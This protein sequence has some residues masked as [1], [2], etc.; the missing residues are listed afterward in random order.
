LVPRRRTSVK[1]QPPASSSLP[2]Q[3]TL[4]EILSQP[5]TWEETKQELER[6]GVFAQVAETF[7]PTDPWL[8]VACGSSYYLSQIIAHLWSRLLK[9]PCRALPASELLFD[10]EKLLRHTGARQV[11][12]LSRSGETTEVLRAAE[13]LNTNGSVLTLGAT[14]NESSS[15]EKLCAHTLKLTS[16]DEKSMV[17]TRSFTSFLLAFQRLGAML[18]QDQASPAVLDRLPVHVRS[19]LRLQEKRI[20]TFGTRQRFTN[21][22]FLGHGAHYW[23]AQE[24]ALKVAEMSSSCAQAYHTLE[25]R[26][27]P[28]SVAGHQSLVTF[29]L[30][31][32]A[33]EEESLLVE[34]LKEL[35][36]ATVVITNRA[37]PRLKRSSGLLVE[38]ALDE[39]E[40]ARLAVAA[41]PAHLLGCAVGIRNGLN[42]DRPKN[43]TRFVT[44]MSGA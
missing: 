44:L 34:E 8:F 4:S 20:R 28:R 33:A 37:T 16:A 40:W 38:I 39:P 5:D 6:R 22:I 26:H 9:A 27:G 12:F 32:A 7:S 11:V 43:L 42:P 3:Y 35:G 31:D 23:L 17:M 13:H 36:A 14:C 19:W 2:G 21:F 1:H 29:L 15:L 41:I 25:F 24:G 30:S 10:S 18:A